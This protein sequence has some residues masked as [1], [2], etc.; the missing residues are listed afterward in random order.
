MDINPTALTHGGTVVIDPNRGHPRD[1][2]SSAP[3]N[4]DAA[5][6]GFFARL[7]GGVTRRLLAPGPGPEPASLTYEV[8]I[9]PSFYWLD[10][11][12][13][14]AE[15]KQQEEM[16]RSLKSDCQDQAVVVENFG[17]RR[18]ALFAGED[19]VIV[20]RVLVQS[21]PTTCCTNRCI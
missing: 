6:K 10:A 21:M 1:A 19:R 4:K 18:G 14:P 20:F 13:S 5:P 12:L 9:R 8:G 15:R 16:A 3:T 11:D 2:A 7:S 17:G